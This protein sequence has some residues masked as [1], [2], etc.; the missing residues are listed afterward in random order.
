MKMDA[1]ELMASL[2][3]F[4]V[5]AVGTTFIVGQFGALGLVVGLIGAVGAA[6]VIYLAGRSER[7]A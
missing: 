5:W 2:L 6:I 3:L 4:C 1:E 7:D